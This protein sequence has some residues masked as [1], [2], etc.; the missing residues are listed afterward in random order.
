MRVKW[1][2]DP[3]YVLLCLCSWKYYGLFIIDIRDD[4][5]VS[6]KQYK[7]SFKGIIF[8]WSLQAHQ[9]STIP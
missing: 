7:L 5:Q 9:F 8:V 6:I 1:D 2:L 3:L 4:S